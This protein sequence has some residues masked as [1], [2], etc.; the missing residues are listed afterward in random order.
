MRRPDRSMAFSVSETQRGAWTGG[1]G[2]KTQRN[3]STLLLSEMG[4]SRRTATVAS[5]D[6]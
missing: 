1:E 3:N 4:H 2:G 6:G 5:G